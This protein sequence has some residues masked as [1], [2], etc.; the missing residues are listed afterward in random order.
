[1]AKQVSPS[2][3][4]PSAGALPQ[5]F[6]VNRPQRGARDG[7]FY[8]WIELNKQYGDIC[9]SM[10]GGRYDPRLYR[11]IRHMIGTITD[12]SI[13]LYAWNLLD[14]AINNIKNDTTLQT[15]SQKHEALMDICDVMLGEIWSFYD[16]FM[17]VT[18]RL[19]MGNTRPPNEDDEDIVG[20][21]ES[22]T[23]M[24]EP[25]EVIEET[26]SANINGET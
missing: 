9:N 11:K 10:D 8:L 13:R 25:T 24:P 20:V 6:D 12:D 1:M 26:N 5:D 4:Q 7:Y 2:K 15:D 3:P 14:G 23:G 19:R 21:V 18:H 22:A 17:G 16:Q